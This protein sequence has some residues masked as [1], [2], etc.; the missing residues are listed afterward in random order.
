[1]P[2]GK[3]TKNQRAFKA[4]ETR[5]RARRW[6]LFGWTAAALGVLFVGWLGWL[7]LYE[8]P[9]FSQLRQLKPQLVTRLYAQGG[10]P[11]QEY[12]LQRRILIPYERIPPFLLRVD[13]ATLREWGMEAQVAAL[14][15]RQLQ[16]L[17][18]QGVP[19]LDNIHVM[20][21]DEPD[22]R[23]ENNHNGLEKL[24]LIHIVRG[25]VLINFVKPPVNI[26]CKQTPVIILMACH[27]HF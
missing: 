21:L 24:L 6:R 3:T 22:N 17:D 18:E 23:L 4:E 12:Y 25:N 20:S 9:S 1:M 15:A 8:L 16:Q 7:Y 14:L 13:E 11:F 27:L 10:T 2:K 5:S 26:F 19:L